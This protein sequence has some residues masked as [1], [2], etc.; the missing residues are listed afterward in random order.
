[1]QHGIDPVR[2][3]LRRAGGRNLDDRAAAAAHAGPDRRARC[4]SQ[5]APPLLYLLHGLSDD[6]TAWTRYT[7]IERYAQAYGLA[8]VMPQVQR[9]FY[10][11]QVHGGRFWTFMTQELPE[12]VQR[13]FHVSSRREDTFVAGLSMGGF[14]AMKW[15]L[16]EPRAVRCCRQPVRGARPGR[17]A[18]HRPTARRRP[19]VVF[20]GRDVSGSGDDLVSIVD[21]LDEAGRAPFR[22]CTSAAAPTTR[23][24]RVAS[25]SW[26]RQRAP[27]SRCTPT[28]GLA[29]TSG[30]CGTRWSRTC[31]PGCRPA[32]VPDPEK[33]KVN[34]V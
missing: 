6:A 33:R 11:D 32:P 22:R 28:C 21:R 12:V 30:R 17:A 13:F 29:A 8:V 23:S 31:S 15:A 4:C 7:S 25:R 34:R 16:H 10:C 26:T 18:A 20:D 14:G 24:W 9:S 5:G 27:G 3:L 1:M 19:G 2:L